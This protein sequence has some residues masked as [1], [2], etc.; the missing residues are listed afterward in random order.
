MI[1]T[2]PLFTLLVWLPCQPNGIESFK[3]K[4]ARWAPETTLRSRDEFFYSSP[5]EASVAC[6]LAT[7]ATGTI[8]GSL[9]GGTLPCNGILCSP[10]YLFP[11][12]PT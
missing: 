7:S 1:F 3:F 10:S 4:V 6:P 9:L 8:H 2:M 5:K 12:Y 11:S